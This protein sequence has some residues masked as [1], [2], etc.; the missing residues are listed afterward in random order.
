[1]NN[2]LDQKGV[3]TVVLEHFEKYVLPRIFDIK[4]AVDSGGTLSNLDIQFLDEALN[5][6]RQYEGFVEDH[7]DYKELFAR[8]AHLYHEITTKALENEKLI[9]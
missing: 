9:N 5:D 3:L 1:M 4:A 7:S 2:P 8:T 6:T